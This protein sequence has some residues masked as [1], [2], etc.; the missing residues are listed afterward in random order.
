M[1]AVL[2][3]V[4][5]GP[6]PARRL[7]WDLLAA[8]LPRC[9]RSDAAVWSDLVSLAAALATDTDARGPLPGLDEVAERCGSTRLVPESRRLVAREPAR[10]DL[11]PSWPWPRPRQPLDGVTTVI[12]GS[13]PTARSAAPASSRRSSRV[14]RSCGR[15]RPAATSASSSG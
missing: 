14:T 1:A 10:L 2:A 13:R 5:R 11:P 9:C 6:L 8:A 15:S 4:A 7:V 3:E 12:P